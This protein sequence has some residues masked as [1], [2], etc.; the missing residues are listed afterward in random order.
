MLMHRGRFIALFLACVAVS[1]AAL[2]QRIGSACSSSYD[3]SGY[4]ISPFW[5]GNA[6]YNG[7]LTFAR[8][9]YQGNWACGPEG[10][11]WAHDFPDMEVH[12]MK[13]L[14][15]L[16]SANPVV[17]NA[18]NKASTILSWND[19][20]VFKYPIAYMSEAYGW[21]LNQNE[22]AGFKRYIQRGGFV[23]FDDMGSQ[24]VNHVRNLVNQWHRAFPDAQLVELTQEHPIFHSFFDIN[25][26]RVVG[27]YERDCG[28]P[29]RYYGFYDSND[30][31][32]RLVAVI[33]DHQDLGEYIEYSDR[34]FDVM[35]TNEA[36]KLMVNYFM[37]ALT[38]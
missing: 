34:G 38:R 30:P 22:I 36:Y 2:A 27:Y 31:H 11:G 29:A 7:R 21:E 4:F 20:E 5:N 28:C 25:L 23:I 14:G 33:N 17:R 16:T 10:P 24:G 1:P 19:P 15:S 6:E 13:I 35:P 3:R 18:T 32:K 26:S 12:F 8:I 37:Y 9:K